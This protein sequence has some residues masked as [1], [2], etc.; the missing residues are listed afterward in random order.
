[1]LR[2]RRHLIL[3]LEQ[4][5]RRQLL[6]ADGLAPSF[7]AF[8]SEIVNDGTALFNATGFDSSDGITPAMVAWDFG[9]GSPVAHGSAQAHVFPQVGTYIVTATLTDIDGIHRSQLSVVEVNPF[10]REIAASYSNG[11]LLQWTFET[12]DGLPIYMG[13]DGSGGQV[14]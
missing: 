11:N 14:T 5:E 2:F 10:Y 1:M 7:T 12:L 13:I 8:Y 4:L 9:D 6:A 3:R